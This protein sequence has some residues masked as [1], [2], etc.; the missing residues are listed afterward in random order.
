VSNEIALP[1][2]TVT[3]KGGPHD[4]QAYTCG[5]EMGYLDATLD[6][7]NQS[8][9]A[10]SWSATIHRENLAQADLVGMQYSLTMRVGEWL[11]ESI[12]ERTRAEWVPVR[13]EWPP[14]KMPVLGRSF[15]C[16]RCEKTS[17]HPTDADFGYCGNCND[18]T[19]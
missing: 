4:D 8:G 9:T 3:S 18:Y 16:P 17:H 2:V 7:L 5:Y 12:D 10:T 14:R 6:A 15:T 19:G 11:E 13:F 1:F